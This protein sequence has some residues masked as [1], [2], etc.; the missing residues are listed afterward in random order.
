MLIFIYGGSA[1]GKSS[2]AQKRLCELAES[3]GAERTYGSLSERAGH[4]ECTKGGSQPDKTYLATMIDDGQ[5]AKERIAAHRKNRE[6][7][8]FTTVECP[9]HI[10]AAAKM[11]GRFVLLEAISNLLANEMFAEEV[12]ERLDT[13]DSAERILSDVARLHQAAEVLV[14][15]SDDIFADGTVYDEAT[16]CYRR[17]LGRLHRRI[18]AEADKVVEVVCGIPVMRKGAKY[19]PTNEVS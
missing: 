13:K 3:Y 2:Y 17:T 12:S 11:C 4:P 16:E 5:E 19:C 14:V 1:S 15:V 7:M 10:G 9:R 8:G 6:N 18:A